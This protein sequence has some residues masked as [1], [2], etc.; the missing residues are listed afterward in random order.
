MNVDKQLADLWGEQEH[1][2]RNLSAEDHDRAAARAKKMCK[3]KNVYDAWIGSMFITA[4]GT[5]S[6]SIQMR[7]AQAKQGGTGK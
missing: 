2:F 1:M 6:R 5:L 4:M 3:S 7:D